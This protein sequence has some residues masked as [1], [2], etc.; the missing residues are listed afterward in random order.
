[1]GEKIAGYDVDATIAPESGEF[2]E[3]GNR[4]PGRFPKPE[5]RPVPKFS[6]LPFSNY[7]F[8]S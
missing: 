8:A 6:T 2:K 7:F 4:F 1:M 5:K 3:L